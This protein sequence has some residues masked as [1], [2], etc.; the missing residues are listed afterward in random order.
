MDYTIFDLI[1]GAGVV[2][3]IASYLLLQLGRLEGTSFAYSL[4][5]CIGA[6]LIMLSLVYSFNLSAFI[7]ELFW[8]LASMIGVVRHLLKRAV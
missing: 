5:N 8:M 7:V 2:L 3:I 4:T 6:G 1:G